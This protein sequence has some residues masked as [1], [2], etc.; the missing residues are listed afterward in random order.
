MD[1]V[2]KALRQ[3][4]ANLAFVPLYDAGQSS[5]VT[6]RDEFSLTSSVMDLVTK[7]LRS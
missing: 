3:D 5:V 7:A 6:G 1:V 2:A 4:V